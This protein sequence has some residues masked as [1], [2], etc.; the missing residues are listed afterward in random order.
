MNRGKQAGFFYLCYPFRPQSQS[1]KLE[2]TAGILRSSAGNG[3]SPLSLVDRYGPA[4]LGPP[5]VKTPAA[6][7][8]PQ[9]RIDWYSRG[10]FHHADAGDDCAA[11]G[12]EN[13]QPDV[14]G[15]A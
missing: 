9:K 7:Q 2:I 10:P 11:L 13:F 8:N 1:R 4:S 3:H 12:Q 6:S 5:T 14:R 15:S